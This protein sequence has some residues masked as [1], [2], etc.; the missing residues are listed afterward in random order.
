M[1][2]PSALRPEEA[3]V[4]IVEDDENNRIILSRLLVLAG[5]A[6]AN[7]L[8]A[9]GDAAAY[10]SATGSEVDVVFLDLQLPRKDGFAVIAELRSRPSASRLKIIALTANVMKEDVER[11]DMAGFDGFLGKPLDGRRFREH[12]ARIL[13]GEEVW[14]PS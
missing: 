6:K 12:F 2:K 5:V 1:E 7:I 11:C 10:L 8:E 3:R 14:V 13:A 9:E 4:L